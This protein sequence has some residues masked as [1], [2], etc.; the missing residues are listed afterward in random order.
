MGRREEAYWK[1]AD[2]S[3]YTICT[4]SYIIVRNSREL[5]KEKRKHETTISTPHCYHH[6]HH[7]KGNIMKV[8]HKVGEEKK[9]S[10]DILPNSKENDVLMMCSLISGACKNN[11]DLFYYH[12]ENVSSCYNKIISKIFSPLSHLSTT[13]N[14]K[15]NYQMFLVKL[16][17]TVIV[18]QI[19]KI[20]M[21][22]Y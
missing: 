6:H 15:T 13:I 1:Q 11:L 7:L 3:L 4:Y 20:N 12:R 14:F 19:H 18:I 9:A 10:T 16:L 17:H 5:G 8:V 22:N 21:D 2:K